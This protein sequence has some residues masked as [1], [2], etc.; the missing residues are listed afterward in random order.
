MD[1]QREQEGKPAI[2]KEGSPFQRLGG[3]GVPRGGAALGNVLLT[4]V[5]AR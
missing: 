2:L 5:S 3:G 1:D 4:G